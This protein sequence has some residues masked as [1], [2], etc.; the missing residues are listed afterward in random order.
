MANLASNIVGATLNTTS[1]ILNIAAPGLGG[2]TGPPLGGFPPPPPLGRIGPDWFRAQPLSPPPDLPLYMPSPAG[3]AGA[4]A[5]QARGKAVQAA[6]AAMAASRAAKQVSAQSLKAE[7]AAARAASINRALLDY[8]YVDGMVKSLN[9]TLEQ[10]LGPPHSGSAAAETRLA[11]EQVDR[12]DNLRRMADDDVN[13]L[14]SVL[15]RDKKMLD[16][17]DPG[18]REAMEKVLTRMGLH[19][20]VVSEIDQSARKQL[21]ILRGQE[22][23]PPPEPPFLPRKLLLPDDSPRWPERLPVPRLPPHQLIPRSGE[24]FL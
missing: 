14:K 24:R 12:T 23:G 22:P 20:L 1:N 11:R 9:N 17:L 10:A 7:V 19:R 16:K 6:L 3:R 4:L 21:S 13:A 18:L 15:K 5:R 8:S 2:L